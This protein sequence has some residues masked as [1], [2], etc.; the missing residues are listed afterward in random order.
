M[1]EV[2]EA[3]DTKEAS[4]V[5]LKALPEG[6]RDRDIDNVLRFRKEAEILRGLSH[7]NIVKIRDSGEWGGSYF[8]VM[9]YVEGTS[10]KRFLE[11]QGPLPLRTFIKIALELARTV[12]FCHEHHILHG[13]LKPGNVMIQAINGSV[14]LK[15]LD[16]GVA[17]IQDR[18]GTWE[19]PA[20]GTFAYM[21][22]ERSGIITRPIDQRSDLYSLGVIFYELLS[23]KPPFVAHDVFSIIHKHIASEPEPLAEIRPDLPRMLCDI[24]A[25]LLRK[26][27]RERYPSAAELIEDLE[28][29]REGRWRD[30][31]GDEAWRRAIDGLE[32]G[33]LAFGRSEELETLESAMWRAEEGDGCAVAVFGEAGSGKT[34]LVAEAQL[35]AVRS[36]GYLLSHDFSES[37]APGPLGGVGNLIDRF[38]W[39]L[40]LKGEGE[41]AIILRGI[42]EEFSSQVD[43]LQAAFPGFAALRGSPRVGS[44]AASAVAASFEA[45]A[46]RLL[47]AFERFLPFLV[48]C[49]DR[50]DLAD[51]MSSR[52][53]DRLSRAARG[54]KLVVIATSR[55]KGFAAGEQ[56][57]SIELSP[58]NE[59]VIASFLEAKLGFPRPA[60][61]TA[62]ALIAE[63][64]DR[65]PS[66]LA[67]ALLGASEP[68]RHAM[69]GEA[70]GYDA[71]IESLRASLAA[72][73][74]TITA[75]E[76]AGL[77]SDEHRAVME[78]LFSFSRPVSLGELLQ[79]FPEISMELA[80]GAC[81]KAASLG[82]ACKRGHRYAASSDSAASALLDRLAPD[83]RRAIHDRIASFLELRR[84][85]SIDS[86]FELLEHW[87]LAGKEGRR[88]SALEYAAAKAYALGSY[89]AALELYRE[90][91][92]GEA[93]GN[94][95]RDLL[96]RIGECAMALSLY[97]EARST[98][99]KLL[100]SEADAPKRAD[101]LWR[102]IRICEAEGRFDDALGF[103]RQSLGIYGARFPSGLRLYVRL[104]WNA[105]KQFS[106]RVDS[107]RIRMEPIDEASTPA[108]LHALYEEIALVGIWSMRL[109]VLFYSHCKAMNLIDAHGVSKAGIVTLL[110]HCAA[111]VSVAVPSRLV[112][113]V[114]RR[115]GDTLNRVARSL[116]LIGSP[117]MHRALYLAVKAALDCGPDSLALAREAMGIAE[118]DPGAALLQEI[119]ICAAQTFEF[120]GSC[121]DLLRLAR[122]VRRKASVSGN[123]KLRLLARLYGALAD[124]LLGKN[125]AA[126]AALPGVAS[127]LEAAG[128]STSAQYAR[129]FL[130]R[131]AAKAG[132]YALATETGLAAIAAM[133]RTGQTHPL[134]MSRVYA[135]LLEALVG[136]LRAY[137]RGSSPRGPAVP[138]GEMRLC[139]GLYRKVRALG[140]VYPAHRLLAARAE[141]AYLA[142]ARGDEDAAIKRLE[143]VESLAER[144]AGAQDR[145]LYREA[146]ASILECRAP[147]AAILLLEK[148]YL[149]YDAMGSR[150]DAA[151]VRELMRR[152]KA[153]ESTDAPARAEPKADASSGSSSQSA[154]REL[155]AVL[156]AARRVSQL[157]GSGYGDMLEHV[158]RLSGA[159]QAELYLL[160]EGRPRCVARACAEGAAVREAPMGIIAMVELSGAPVLLE[161]ASRDGLF[162]SDP[163]VLS[164]ELRSVLCVPLISGAE[165]LGCVYLAH[166]GMAGTFNEHTKALVE[167]L[168][169]QAASAIDNARLRARAREISRHL[170][171]L[172]DAVPIAI[173]A[174]DAEARP[175]HRNKEAVALHPRLSRLGSGEALW[176]LA[177]SLLPL[178]DDFEKAIAENVRVEVGRIE[179]ADSVFAA[180]I[181]PLP[182]GGGA[183]LALQD[184]TREE[185]MQRQLMQS[186]KMEA[187]GTLVGGIAHDFNNIL[188]GILATAQILE[189]ELPQ[190][191]DADPA[192]R[193]DLRVISS[194]ARRAADLVKQLMGLSASHSA[195]RIPVDL[196][197]AVDEVLKFARKSFDKGISI[198][199]APPGEPRFSMGDPAQVEQVILNVLINAAHS[200]TIMRSSE[201]SWGGT[202]EV[203]LGALDADIRDRV[204]GLAPSPHWV[205][206]VSDEGVGIDEKE[207]DRIFEP[208]YTTKAQGKGTG[209]GLAMVYSLMRR[210]GGTVDVRSAPGRGSCF[211][212]IF[213][214]S[215]PPAE[216]ARARAETGAKCTGRVLVVED[217][218]VVRNAVLRYLQREGFE[219]L[220]SA[221]GEDA[222]RAFKEEGPFDLV[223]LDLVMPR[224]SGRFV[225]HEIRAQRPD[226]PILLVSG[227]PKD[228][229]VE[230]LLEGGH[231][232]FLQKPFNLDDLARAIKGLVCV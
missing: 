123:E 155:K 46:Y 124:Y 189:G 2:W 158:M 188:M 87:R 61:L 33:R 118:A 90:L 40:S 221:D 222:T 209:L 230:G 193:E 39:L 74:A 41:R 66:Q 128:D 82:L 100:G 12:R 152:S 173:I 175:K 151:R 67:K 26:D 218:E 184:V 203:S 37:R 177:P 117:P 130:V 207:L 77:L 192:P 42:E 174:L 84:E 73:G 120:F 179:I 190:G 167:S 156:D 9:D 166:H 119:S 121:E 103:A 72:R 140:S 116:E 210:M 159:Q 206:A 183:V 23:G 111:I 145:A 211:R 198:R 106:H 3:F 139:A 65:Y 191:A 216:E 49:F 114:Y 153:G 186:Q 178:K 185:R 148:A 83:A 5:A 79:C 169:S 53:M 132:R 125:K 36:G 232:A 80:L 227:F 201:E 91:L 228:E 60:A 45:L 199:W 129:L 165:R 13:D 31:L 1:G 57:R 219:A 11:E 135:F 223:V 93:T 16:F 78:R 10:L 52:V 141:A 63:R 163:Q 112:P 104:A 126:L 229:R 197:A 115:A 154:I 7:E 96:E 47:I 34:R 30:V 88:R 137:G 50:A 204:P 172:L 180:S 214:A 187:V 102:L 85:E 164:Q 200:M 143:A 43:F 157:A 38:F 144:Y 181:S 202:I 17:I 134:V 149:D 35:K 94:P 108:K 146:Y 76:N 44:R 161:D 127:D 70:S 21:A 150:R 142:Y 131:A 86:A 107:P 205:V 182:A 92:A 20:V 220:A 217:E 68:L 4:Q 195:Q 101:F 32:S 98:Y 168:A 69:S 29:A 59:C 196:G 231:S 171:E 136:R 95:R 194:S 105:F 51:P 81:A 24:V 213:P 109:D 28:A 162:R 160:E 62:A 75:A 176:K 6:S 64:T 71:V 97:E 226:Q 22:P 122:G 19:A 48:V 8:L 138:R 15:I 208:F 14:K 170:S 147:D 55:P 54:R 56:W 133:R 212:L 224:R 99:L 25:R 113:L 215:D 110:T 89:G 58:L 18:S 27:A 225:H